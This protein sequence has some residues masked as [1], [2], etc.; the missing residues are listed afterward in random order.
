MKRFFKA[1]TATVLAVTMIFSLTACGQKLALGKEMIKCESQLDAVVKLDQGTLDAVVIDSI[2]AGYYA[3]TGDYAGKI[4]IVEDL[5]LAQEEYGIAG[6]KGDKAFVSKI[7]DALIALNSNGKLGEVADKF[8]VKGSLAVKADTTNPLASADDDSWTKIV[9]SKK[10]VIGYTVFAPIAYE[11]AGAL[12][13]FD[14]ELAK[15]VVKY[16]NEQNST[17]IKVEFLVINWDSKEAL[18]EEGSI[19]LVWNGMTITEERKES[20]CISVPYLYNKQV[21]VVATAD[22]DKY[23]D[24]DS[25]KNAV[26]GVE[27]GSAGQ[28][29]VEGPSEE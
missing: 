7:N 13:G 19:D 26:I 22:K 11:E 12:T 6:R 18:L 17:D 10:I 24:K 15:E 3:K 21:A 23:S 2:M 20:M 14:I 4:A 8:G 29:C 1:L 5:V 25:F 27:K 9:N 16:L 28:S